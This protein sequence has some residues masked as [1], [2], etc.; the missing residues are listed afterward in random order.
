MAEKDILK[1]VEERLEKMDIEIDDVPEKIL[2]YLIKIETEVTKRL[3]EEA[4]AIEEIKANAININTISK[5][6]IIS[7]KTIYNHDILANY[8][9]ACETEYKKRLPAD[10]DK[11]TALKN[12]LEEAEDTVHL[13]DLNAVDAEVLKHE[14]DELHKEIADLNLKISSLTIINEKLRTDDSNNEDELDG[15]QSMMMDFD[16]NKVKM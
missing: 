7:N 8:I 3:N 11:I 14:I 12:R 4:R 2:S 15:L 1:T 9:K 5:A 10:K 6:G 16:S 13:F